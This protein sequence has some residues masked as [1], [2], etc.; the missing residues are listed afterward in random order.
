MTC[1]RRTI[2]SELKLGAITFSTTRYDFVV[3]GGGSAGL[4]AARFAASRGR[5]VA[6]IE[7]NRLGGD[8]T[9]TGCVPSKALIRAARVAHEA[10]NGQR[11]GI[12]A[13]FLPVS[14]SGV[15]DRIGSV[16]NDIYRAESP[17]SLKT[18]GIDTYFEAAQLVDPFTLRAGNKVIK[19]KKLLI[20]TGARPFVPPIPGLNECNFLTYETLWQLDKLPKRLLAIGGGPIGCELAQALHRLGSQVTLLEATPRLLGQDE[21]EVSDL[22]AEVLTNEGISL[23][24][25]TPVN[26]ICESEGKLQM[27]SGGKHWTADGLLVAT[28]RRP[29]IEGLGLEE[30]GVRFNAKGIATN[31]FL[32]TS[33][34]HIYGAG[35]CLDGPEFTHY[36]GW[37]GFMAARNALLPGKSPGVRDTIPWATF[38]EPEVAKVGL[39]EREA[40]EKYGDSI[41]TV[42]WPLNGVDR[43]VIDGAQ[44]GFTKIVSRKSGKLVGA[45]VVSPRAGETIHELALAIDRGLKLGDLANTLHIYPTYSMALMQMAAEDRVTRLLSGLSGR[46]LRSLRGG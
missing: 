31:R 9:W 17:E 36:A 14:F 21:P 43:P 35:D 20:C 25:G 4:T 42:H 6:I 10:N 30:A 33:Q 44:E 13:S 1:A 19:F 11:F 18:D 5:S 8:C 40:R 28:G 24:L 16:I 41:A 29:N 34:P 2:A 7:V 22:I 3:I 38:T 27:H 26:S 23:E 12:E 39:T 37:Q 45:T 46:L 15:M 32:Q